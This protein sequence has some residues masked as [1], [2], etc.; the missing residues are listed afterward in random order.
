VWRL[1]SNGKLSAAGSKSPPKRSL[2]GHLQAWKG[3]ATRP[4]QTFPNDELYGLTSQMRR[5][6]VSVASNIRR[7]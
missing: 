4:T 6:A 5:A 2:G 1:T 3:S 7:G